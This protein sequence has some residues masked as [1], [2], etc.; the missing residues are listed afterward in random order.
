MEVVLQ[1]DLGVTGQGSAE[2][3]TYI[4]SSGNNG[5]GSL[6]VDRGLGQ[7]ELFDLPP[8]DRIL[9]TNTKLVRK[10]GFNKRAIAENLSDGKVASLFH[11]E[12]VLYVLFDNDK[13]LRSFDI[14]SGE[15]ISEMPLPKVSQKGASK[16][17]EGIAIH[18]HTSN[19]APLDE[20]PTY[21]R[22]GKTKS[23][24]TKVIVHLALDS[25]PQLWSFSV[26][27]QGRGKLAF[28]DC[29]GTN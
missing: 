11:F 7:L 3:I 20:D 27:E 10:D 13:V 29:A 25:P 1:L 26:E 8:Q 21:L 12:G 5:K 22:N 4:P 14:E 28:P 2:G 18:R 23:S 9:E 17:W 16:Q 15:M 24:Q 6:C 19:F